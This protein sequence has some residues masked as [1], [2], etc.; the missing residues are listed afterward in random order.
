MNLESAIL[1][2]AANALWQAPLALAVGGLGARAVRGLGAR[3]EHRVWVAALLAESVLPALSLVR[4]EHIGTAL[5]AWMTARGAEDG[6]VQVTM[7]ASTAATGWTL[8]PLALHM[9][10]A[11]YAG[12]TLYFAARLGWQFLRVCALRRSARVLTLDGDAE[13][14]WRRLSVRGARVAE[15]AYVPAPLTLGL[16]RPL[17][18]VPESMA[19]DVGGAEMETVLAHECAHIER[20]DF[21][22]NLAYELLTLP[23]RLHPACWAARARVTE[24]REMVCDAMA[25]EA[26]GRVAYG[27]SLL[28]LAAR[29]AGNGALRVPL[30]T[31]I[32]DTNGLERRLMKLTETQQAIRGARRLAMTVVCVALGVGT[33][34]FAL[35]L[36]THV[37][38]ATD[39]ATPKTGA[40][41]QVPSDKI[42]ANLDHKVQPVYPPEAKKARVQGKVVLAAVIGKDGIIENLRVVSGPKKLQE[43]ALDAVK[44]WTYKPYLLNGEPVE[45]ETKINV[46]YTLAK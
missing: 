40:A 31:G 13:R 29:L 27:H 39:T 36:R 8:P 14:V 19:A 12:G 1:T 17:L 21:A 35:G 32:F 45:V 20:R 16:R 11:L 18:L 6:A 41:I 28:R 30:A 26:A 25:A 2:Y 44:Q 23:V 3:A 5:R 38:A 43:S 9:G 15:S 10:V 46:I 42:V 34:A 24:T 22:K 7:Q 4:W 33:C 37:A